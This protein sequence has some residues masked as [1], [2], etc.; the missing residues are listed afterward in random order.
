MMTINEFMIK[1]VT[2]NEMF[3][4]L[5]ACAEEKQVM[6]GVELSEFMSGFI[7]C[8]YLHRLYEGFNNE[9]HTIHGKV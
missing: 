9:A 3:E 4:S 7:A 6:A 5:L 8:W 2:N 1:A